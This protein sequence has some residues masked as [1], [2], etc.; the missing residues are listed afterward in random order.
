LEVERKP[1]P[2]RDHD[3][4]DVMA[5]AITYSAPGDVTKQ[6]FER[7]QP[8]RSEPI[9]DDC[10]KQPEGSLPAQSEGVSQRSFVKLRR[11]A[12]YPVGSRLALAPSS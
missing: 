1:A 7:F 3:E 6:V 2:G 9:Y 11:H 5:A 8:E 12:N 4:S 10:Q